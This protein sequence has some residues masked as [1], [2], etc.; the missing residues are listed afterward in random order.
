MFKMNKHFEVYVKQEGLE[1]I[2]I[3]LIVRTITGLKMQS[4]YLS[5]G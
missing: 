4:I 2:L 1:I 5:Y 3:Y